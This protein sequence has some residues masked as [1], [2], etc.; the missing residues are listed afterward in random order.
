MYSLAF[1]L[2]AG[3]AM[4]GTYLVAP[5]REIKANDSQITS[6]DNITSSEESEDEDIFI[7]EKMNPR[8]YLI[9]NLSQMKVLSGQAD[10]SLS[11]GEYNIALNISN[12]YLTLETLS[13][14]ELNLAATLSV[15]DV[16]C[17]IEA[18]FVNNVIYLTL[19][20]NDIK[21]ETSSF[22]E[23]ITMIQSFGLPEISLPSFITDINFDTL[24]NNLGTMPYY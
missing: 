14:I 6:N 5:S 21:L 10:L 18:S 19:N 15:N 13:D 24:Q 1:S 2:A 8:D 20:D 23:I 3:V 7:P 4:T 12:L 16:S 11:I 17:S 22:S 9:D